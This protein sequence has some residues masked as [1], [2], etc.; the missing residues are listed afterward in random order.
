M[1]SLRESD[2]A[3]RVVFATIAMGMGFILKGVNLILHYGAPQ[4][5]FKRVGEGTDLV[6]V[7]V[8]LCIGGQQKVP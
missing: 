2:G 7:P 1:K 4:S 8:Q 6:N 3:V 5:I